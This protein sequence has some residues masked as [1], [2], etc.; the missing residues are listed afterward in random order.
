MD[1]STILFH[2]HSG[3]RYLVL[4]AGV[5]SFGYSLA[6]MLQ[7]RPW[8]RTGRILLVSFVGILD[9]QVLLG[10]VLVFVWAFYPALWGHI[11]MMV[12]AAVVAHVAAA[13]NKRR[14]AERQSHR[15]AVLGVAGALILVVG[16]IAA[17]GRSIV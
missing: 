15:L 10:L 5:L 4:L 2:A 8:D 11:S 7:G 9:L 17:I 3:L 1:A 6:R 12:L 13:L 14:P 16:G